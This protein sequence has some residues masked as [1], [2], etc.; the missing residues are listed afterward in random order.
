VIALY[1]VKTLGFMNAAFTYSLFVTFEDQIDFCI[2]VASCV[3]LLGS[4]DKI[5]QTNILG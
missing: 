4:E 5:L 2:Q 3:F 1:I